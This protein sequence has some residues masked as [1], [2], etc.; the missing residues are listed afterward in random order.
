MLE[1]ARSDARELGLNPTSVIP[2]VQ[3]QMNAAR[4]VQN[5][6]LKRWDEADA[7]AAKAVPSEWST[8]KP[9]VV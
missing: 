8:R 6:W 1:T 5:C 9:V 7:V 2:F 3:E 4:E